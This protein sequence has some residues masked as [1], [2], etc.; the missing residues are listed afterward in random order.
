LLAGGASEDSIAEAAQLARASRHPFSRALARYAG[1]GL[2][3]HDIR[4]HPGQGISGT[5]NGRPARLGTAKFVSGASA[6]G[7]ELWFS[8]GGAPAVAFQFEDRIRPDARLAIDELRAMGISAEILSGDAEERVAHA[9]DICGVSHWTARATPQSKAA[10][11][12]ELQRGGLKVLMVG[13]GLNDAG[14]LAGAHAAIAPGGA[15]DVFRLAS[16]CVFS[17]DSLKAIVR[18]VDISRKARAHMRQN[19][20]FAAFY[21]VVA[22]PVAL[23]GLATPMV[24]AIAMSGSS[25]VVTLNA[26]RL[27]GRTGRG[28]AVQP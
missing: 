26:L 24:A 10:R 5:I 1:V 6:S 14:A 15:V 28:R 21:N 9:A 22:V 23:A 4:E 13:D 11:L 20:A 8:I 7:S 2:V 17:G 3:A 19:F 27:V 16:D 25:V 12:E 18:I